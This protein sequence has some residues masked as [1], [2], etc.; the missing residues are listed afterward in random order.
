ME[1]S[2]HRLRCMLNH[3]GASHPVEAPVSITEESG[4]DNVCIPFLRAPRRPQVPACPSG[5]PVKR[6]SGGI[7]SESA[8]RSRSAFLTKRRPPAILWFLSDR[9][10]RNS[11]RRAKSLF[12]FRGCSACGRATFQR[13]KVAASSQS[14][15]CSGRPGRPSLAPLP[16]ASFPTMNRS[17]GFMVGGQ[18][19]ACG[20]GPRRVALFRWHLRP[21]RKP[22]E[23]CLNV[24]TAVLLSDLF[25]CFYKIICA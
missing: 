16:C 19:R 18:C 11:P 1:P 13:R 10:E 22:H 17:A 21:A 8:R 23:R 5:S 15:L 3:L 6:G 24:I 4:S 20:P 14:P 25:R 12:C 7:V 9:S 2:V